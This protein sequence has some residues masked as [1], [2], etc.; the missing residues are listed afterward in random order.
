MPGTVL[1]ASDITVSENRQRSYSHRAHI[2]VWES[3]QLQTRK[4]NKYKRCKVVI[5]AKKKYKL[6]KETGWMCGVVMLW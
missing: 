1:D 2:L 3:T 6:G 5:I 4:A